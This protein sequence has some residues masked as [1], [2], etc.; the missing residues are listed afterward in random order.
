MPG[1]CIRIRSPHCTN[2]QLSSMLELLTENP[3]PMRFG[4]NSKSVLALLVLSLEYV[5]V[6]IQD[7]HERM[8]SSEIIIIRDV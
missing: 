6:N 8:S 2:G 1:Y 4:Q 3:G 5:S 7:A